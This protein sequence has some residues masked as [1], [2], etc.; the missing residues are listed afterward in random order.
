MKLT[1]SL[2]DMEGILRHIACKKYWSL[3]DK[4]DAY[5]HIRV[6][7]EHVER[8]TMTTPDRN[9]VDLVMQQ[10][11]CNAIA[12]YQTLM[13]HIFG[14]Y[15]GVFMDVCLDDVV[16]YS[17]SL[18]NCVNHCKQVID[19]LRREKLYLSSTKLQFLNSE[20]EDYW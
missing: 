17:D 2:P 10:G 14:P 19:V 1:S 13:K 4:K 15:I 7:P 11:D 5:E 12:T 6:V 18:E 20:M 9:M 3:I 8:T 16:V